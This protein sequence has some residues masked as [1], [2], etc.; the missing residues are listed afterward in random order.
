MDSPALTFKKKKYQDRQSSR[1]TVTLGWQKRK[2]ATADSDLESSV[3]VFADNFGI[4][5]SVVGALDSLVGVSESLV[6]CIDSDF[7]VLE[8]HL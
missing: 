1:I 5:E 8:S 7:K 6:G 3:G 2:N 4:L